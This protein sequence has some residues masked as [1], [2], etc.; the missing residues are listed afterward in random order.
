MRPHTMA[1][2]ILL[3]LSLYPANCQERPQGIPEQAEYDTEFQKFFHDEM[4]DGIWRRR[5]WTKA[6]DLIYETISYRTKHLVVERSIENAKITSNTW[7]DTK[8]RVEISVTY[9]KNG[10]PLGREIKS[11]NKK[12]EDLLF[13]FPERG[14]HNDSLPMEESEFKTE[15]SIVRTIFYKGKIWI[16]TTRDLDS[17]METEIVYDREGVMINRITKKEGGLLKEEIFPWKE[18]GD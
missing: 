14:I 16:E 1:G 15:N 17:G 13:N 10:T 5:T 7:R 6:G 18:E 2:V 3:A 12:V 8:D 4:H 9:A 11:K